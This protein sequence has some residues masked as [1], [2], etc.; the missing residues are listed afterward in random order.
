V[1]RDSG[2]QLL[3]IAWD[4]STNGQP[5]ARGTAR[6]GLVGELAVMA[7]TPEFSDKLLITAVRN[8]RGGLHLISW[9][10]S[11]G[12]QITR[13]STLEPGILIRTVDVSLSGP[14]GF[15]NTAC[16]N[17]EGTM[18]IHQWKVETNG[19]MRSFGSLTFAVRAKFRS[20]PTAWPWPIP[21]E[22]CGQSDFGIR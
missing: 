18:L 3:L 4:I 13:L 14:E 15:F 6:A 2:H 11:S 8:S 1:V 21:T 12:G 16:T 19:N 9:R 22:D 20:I 17:A 7:F 5:I 10:V